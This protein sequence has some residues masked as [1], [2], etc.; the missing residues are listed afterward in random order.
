MPSRS[1]DLGEGGGGGEQRWGLA[2][3]WDGNPRYAC[4]LPLW[5]RSAQRFSKAIETNISVVILK[6]SKAVVHGCSVDVMSHDPSHLQAAAQ[7]Y[8][9]RHRHHGY[10]RTMAFTILKLALFA[11]T[12][13]DVVFYAD[14]D[15]DAHSGWIPRS[16]TWKAQLKAFTDSP[17]YIAA[18][19]DHSS[20]V[21]TGVMLIKPR[22]WLYL[23]IANVL[24]TNLTFDPVNG[25]NGVGR[26]R[27]LLS[28]NIS[29]LASGAY[30]SS[31]SKAVE[32]ASV[33]LN[34][35]MG[36]TRNEWNFVCSPVDQGLFWWLFFVRRDWGTWTHP[37]LTLDHYWGPTKPWRPAGEA[38]ST[39]QSRYLWR[40]D[41]T[42]DW[43][44]N[45]SN[46]TRELVGYMKKL[47]SRGAYVNSSH[48]RSG[49]SFI[50]RRPW[51]PAMAIQW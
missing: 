47:L 1:V 29:R 18:S 42:S 7:S 6:P 26:P 9:R 49:T 39:V 5:C 15:V 30:N 36:Y 38:R 24:S 50:D 43:A 25:F 37:S 45:V 3:L 23:E 28:V 16:S 11:L 31:S 46:C 2:T 14:L 51:L 22:R 8:V 32:A 44:Q 19:P 27:S 10:I 34:R 4:A 35:T 33:R 17:I 41:P 21:N 13:F 40:L 12:D 20:P 48:K